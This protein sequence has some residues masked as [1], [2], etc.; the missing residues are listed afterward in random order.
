MKIPCFSAIDGEDKF[1]LISGG[2][3]PM[4]ISG[5]RTKIYHFIQCDDLDPG[6]SLKDHKLKTGSPD[7]EVSFKR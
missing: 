4:S 6:C 7:P 1:K 5:F 3:I 2:I